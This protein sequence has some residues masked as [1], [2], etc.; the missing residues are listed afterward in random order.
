MMPGS[1]PERRAQNLLEQFQ[2]QDVD[3]DSEYPFGPREPSIGTLQCGG[4]SCIDSVRN[5]VPSDNWDW[6]EIIGLNF[7]TLK[8]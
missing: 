5:P 3:S 2:K 7:R 6:C 8:V 4:S 1:D